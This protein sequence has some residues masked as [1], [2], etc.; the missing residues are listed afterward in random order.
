MLVPPGQ[1]PPSS[2][3][4]KCAGDSEANATNGH[5]DRDQPAALGRA[6]PI[7]TASSSSD[8]DGCRAGDEDLDRCQPDELGDVKEEPLQYPVRSSLLGADRSHDLGTHRDLA[9]SAVRIGH[10]DRAGNAAHLVSQ[11]HDD[12]VTLPLPG[13][14]DTDDAG[15]GGQA[16][17][18]IALGLPG[19]LQI[20]HAASSLHVA[21]SSS[22]A[23]LNRLP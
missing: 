16:L 4:L 22:S 23:V 18:E 13:E 21:P 1:D 9:L 5:A 11:S 14:T 15:N 10:R 12:H 6:D 3:A 19:L 17:V 7:N 20:A 2:N 8:L